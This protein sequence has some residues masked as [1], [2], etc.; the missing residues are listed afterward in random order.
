MLV[1]TKLRGYWKAA[2]D[3]MKDSS[4]VLG[5]LE[6]FVLFNLSSRIPRVSI[7]HLRSEIQCGLYDFLVFILIL[8]EAMSIEN[9]ADC[10]WFP[11]HNKKGRLSMLSLFPWNLLLSGNKFLLERAKILINNERL[12]YSNY[13]KHKIIKTLRPASVQN[14][15]PLI[16]SFRHWIILI[17]K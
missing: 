9:P 16:S 3:T 15:L 4:S 5:H 7:D 8:S 12:S 17:E 1:T 13:Q 14:V 6:S 10:G 11:S 2:G